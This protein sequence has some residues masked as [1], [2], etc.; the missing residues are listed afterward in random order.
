[1]RPGLQAGAAARVDAVVTRDMVATLGGT[2]IHPVLAT[3]RMIEWM[4]WAGRRL[5]LPYLEADEDAVGYAVQVRHLKPTLVG[6]P[7]WAIARFLA[8][9]GARLTVA[10]EAHNPAGLIGEGEFVQ[11]LV[12]KNRLNHLITE[13]QKPAL[14]KVQPDSG[15]PP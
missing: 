4:E 2:P 8:R 14:P 15:K 3:A 13:A 5:I 11:A 1:M 9:D 7:F 12:Q 10:V 6:Q